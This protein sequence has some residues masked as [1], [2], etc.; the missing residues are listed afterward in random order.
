MWQR[1][2]LLSLGMRDIKISELKLIKGTEC[3]AL[4]RGSYTCS[5]PK[6]IPQSH[7]RIPEQYD[8]Q[9]DP[10]TTNKL[11][12]VCRFKA[13]KKQILFGFVNAAC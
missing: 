2:F 4:T 3:F 12:A 1:W 10:G 7:L 6:T 11:C 5:I 13:G 8:T 9:A